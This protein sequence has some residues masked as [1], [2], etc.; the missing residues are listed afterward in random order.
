MSV[1]LHGMSN[2]L[3]IPPTRSENQSPSHISYMYSNDGEGYLFQDPKEMRH[4]SHIPSF[5]IEEKPVIFTINDSPVIYYDDRFISSLPR[6]FEKITLP[7]NPPQELLDKIATI[8]NFLAQGTTY[9]YVKGSA[10]ANHDT[11][12]FKVTNE[13]HSCKVTI[14]C[15]RELIDIDY[16]DIPDENVS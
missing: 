13:N 9:E 15:F 8:A 10:Q 14:P 12:N 4:F 1:S 11:L 6:F 7:E 16:E 2:L 3:K 5:D